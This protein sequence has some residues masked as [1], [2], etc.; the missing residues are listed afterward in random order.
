[1]KISIGISE[2]IKGEVEDF[3]RGHIV[4][5][6]ELPSEGTEDDTKPGGRTVGTGLAHAEDSQEY[7]HLT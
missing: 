5:T 2:A 6:R 3:Q 7:E 4:I 1:M